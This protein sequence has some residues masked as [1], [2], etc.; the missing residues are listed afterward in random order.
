MAKELTKSDVQK[1]VKDE[2]ESYMSKQL[3]KEMARAIKKSNSDP[4]KEVIEV[5]RLAIEKLAEFLWV[6]RNVWKGDIK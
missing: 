2:I 6:R 5:A 1:I 3:E 4:R